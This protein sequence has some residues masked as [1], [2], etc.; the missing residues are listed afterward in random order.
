MAE[1]A[2]NNAKN[3]STSHIS[4]K[5]NWVYHPWV[6]FQE[7]INPYSRPYFTN[8]LA[9]ELKELMEVCYQNLLHAQEL[10]KKA[11]DKRV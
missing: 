10:Q 5:L 7:D 9:E 4:F 1:F 6:S 8:K 2:F 11:H 3:T